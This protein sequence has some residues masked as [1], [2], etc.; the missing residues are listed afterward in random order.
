VELSFVGPHVK[1]DVDVYKAVQLGFGIAYTA[2]AEEEDLGHIGD[3]YKSSGRP[4][5]TI[6]PT[7]SSWNQEHD[8]VVLRYVITEGPEVRFGEIL[9]RGHFK[10]HGSTIRRD[11]PFKAGD[12]YDVNKIEAAERNLQT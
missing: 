2:A 6:D 8:R 7:T 5:V 9:I 1:N 12:L 10:T 11:L 4:F 3:L